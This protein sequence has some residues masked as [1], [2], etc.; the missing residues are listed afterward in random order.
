MKALQDTALS[1]T[2][3]G[4]EQVSSVQTLVLKGLSGRIFLGFLTGKESGP[5]RNMLCDTE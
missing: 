4:I 5:L 3:L 1:A 2:S